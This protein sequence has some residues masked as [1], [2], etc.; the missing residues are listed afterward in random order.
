MKWNEAAHYN[1]IFSLRHQ[2]LGR[3]ARRS[4]RHPGRAEGLQQ[5]PVLFRQA[6]LVQQVRAPQPGPAQRLHP[7]PA[8][9]FGVVAG[10]QYLGNR[11]QFVLDR[12]GVVRTV[13]QAIGPKAV[14]L[15]R[16]GV[17]QGAFLQP[18]HGI[19]QHRCRQFAAGQ[20]VVADG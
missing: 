10:Q 18:G 14:L 16:I 7:P 1:G 2:C 8:R 11:A 5:D 4:A 20:H 12:P 13:E 6:G 17:V 19:D 15:A 9:D 3:I